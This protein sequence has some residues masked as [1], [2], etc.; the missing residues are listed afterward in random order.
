MPNQDTA[1]KAM[2]QIRWTAKEIIP[3][4]DSNIKKYSHGKDFTPTIVAQQLNGYEKRLRQVKYIH[5]RHIAE[6]SCGNRPVYEVDV[7]G[8]F[9]FDN[10]CGSNVNKFVKLRLKCNKCGTASKYIRISMHEFKRAWRSRTNL[11]DKWNSHDLVYFAL[12]GLHKNWNWI[13][14]RRTGKH[15][16]TLN[17]S[18]IIINI[19]IKNETNLIFNDD[20]LISKP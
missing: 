14:F 7:R 10:Y 11:F 5:A 15:H 20:N 17:F 1:Y 3:S 12:K 19:I 4:H 18:T 8:A 16:T 13:M 6:C 2:E 9:T